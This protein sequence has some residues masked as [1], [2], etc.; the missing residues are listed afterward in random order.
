M[1]GK[2]RQVRLDAILTEGDAGAEIYAQ[3]Q[4]AG[5]E[6]LG[7]QF[8]LHT[9]P[10]NADEATVLAIQGL[11]ADPQVHAMM[12]FLPLPEGV[13]R[14][15]F[16]RP[17][18]LNKDVEGSILPTFGNA[19]FGRRSLVPCTALAVRHMLERRGVDLCGVVS[20]GWP[21]QHRGKTDCVVVDAI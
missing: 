21:I 12:M 8:H 2:G 18:I 17:L 19:V 20:R 6:Q 4:R 7:I 16:R 3:R 10:Q 13:K 11:N 14:N 15:A 5:A 9:I 1:A